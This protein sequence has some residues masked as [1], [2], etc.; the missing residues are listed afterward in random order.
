MAVVRKVQSKIIKNT[1]E[2]ASQQA[3]LKVAKEEKILKAKNSPKIENDRS[4]DR[5]Q[6]T[7]LRTKRRCF[8]CSKKISPQYWDINSLRRFVSDRGRIVSRSRSSLCAKHQKRIAQHIKYARHL[9]LLPF[10][11]KI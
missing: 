10:T 1:D 7:G 4:K 11:I 3:N 5:N 6:T 8:Y 9:S 2:K